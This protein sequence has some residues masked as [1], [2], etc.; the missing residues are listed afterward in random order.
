[1]KTQSAKA[2]GRRLQQWVRDK[3]NA[4]FTFKDGDVSS[5]SMGAGGTDLILSPN[6]MVYFPYA[7]ECKNTEKLNLWG[8]W[9]QAQANS[10]KEA[11]PLLVI[12]RNRQAPLVVVDAETFIALHKKPIR[13]ARGF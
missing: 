3:I 10:T 1:M 9:E 6:A 5:R 13:T 11:K 4:H 12:A 2:K 7:I 8:A